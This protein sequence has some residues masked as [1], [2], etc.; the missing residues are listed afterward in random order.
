MSSRKSIFSP[1]TFV[2]WNLNSSFEIFNKYYDQL[3][4]NKYKSWNK[5]R[6]LK[7]NELYVN[8]QKSLV[9]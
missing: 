8:D 9:L 4:L 1:W 7:M 2:H 6:T 3:V 5:N